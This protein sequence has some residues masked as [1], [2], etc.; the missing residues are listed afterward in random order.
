MSVS[1]IILTISRAAVEMRLRLSSRA[2][3]GSAW[4]SICSM[5]VRW[6][7]MTEAWRLRLAYTAAGLRRFSGSR[8]ISGRNMKAL[9]IALSMSR[10][11]CQYSPYSKLSTLSAGRRRCA[12]RMIRLNKW[13]CTIALANDEYRPPLNASWRLNDSVSSPAWKAASDDGR[14]VVTYTEANLAQQC[15]EA[16]PFGWRGLPRWSR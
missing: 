10:C 13:L 7:Q 5:A 6:R 9:E 3:S 16:Q 11:R 8:N 15:P 12:W 4:A 1:F 2:W 14:C